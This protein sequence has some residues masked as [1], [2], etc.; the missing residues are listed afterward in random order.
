MKDSFEQLVNDIKKSRKECPWMRE[1][2]LEKQKDELLAEAN[3]VAEAID[4]ED[5]ENLKEEL[6]DLLYDLLH[7]IEI[8]AEN[9]L[10]TAKEVIDEVTA[11]I[12]RRKPYV[13]GDV[14][15]N[16]IEEAKAVWQEIKKQEKEAKKK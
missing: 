7:L 9:R 1:Q 8:G 2:T 3:E 14:K 16:T 6:G 11:K 13:F 15:V 4:K 5:F 12:R 10:F